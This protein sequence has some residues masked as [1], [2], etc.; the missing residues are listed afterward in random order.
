[1]QQQ[2]YVRKGHVISD[3]DGNAVFTGMV[4]AGALSKPSI[5][6]AKRESRRLQ[7]SALG[8]GILRVSP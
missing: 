6:A 7:G 3:M 8:R 5:N 1:M 4:L 2:E